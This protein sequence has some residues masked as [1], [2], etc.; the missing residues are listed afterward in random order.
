MGWR[1]A[2]YIGTLQG[3]GDYSLFLLVG[4]ARPV[5]NFFNVPTTAKTYAVAVAVTN[6]NAGGWNF[7]H[8]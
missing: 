7:S 2:S 4:I 6:F 5:A 8:S 1:L 3:F